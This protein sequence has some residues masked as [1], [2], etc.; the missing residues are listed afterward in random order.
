MKISY[1]KIY[2]TSIKSI[3]VNTILTFLGKTVSCEKLL[4]FLTEHLRLCSENGIRVL[5]LVSDMAGDNQGLWN[6]LGIHAHKSH[7]NVATPNPASVQDTLLVMD[8]PSHAL[9]NLKNA[10]MKYKIRVP[11]WFLQKAGFKMCDNAASTPLML[12]DIYHWLDELLS[13]KESNRGGL[14]VAFRL[15]K[16]HLRPSNWEKMRVSNTLGVLNLHT[17]TALKVCVELGMPINFNL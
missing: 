11:V 7:V 9:K 1:Y 5:M 16:C 6:L 14:N 15:R 12:V 3:F 13:L 8:D 10:M 2:T 17:V 4:K